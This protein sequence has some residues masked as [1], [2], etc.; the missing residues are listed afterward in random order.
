M[1]PEP[2]KERTMSGIADWGATVGIVLVFLCIFSVPV[3]LG[4]I[5]YS[6]E[7]KEEDA[8]AL[9]DVVLDRWDMDAKTMELESVFLDS[10]GRP[11]IFE[12]LP[13]GRREVRSCGR[14]GESFT[15]DDIVAI[16]PR[17]GHRE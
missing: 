7:D 5:E 4:M 10:W 11:L 8:Q 6:Q 17:E 3:I 16:D 14:D 12:K 13:Y 15:K 1:N 2:G 9:V